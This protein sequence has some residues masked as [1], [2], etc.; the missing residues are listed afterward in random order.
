MKTLMTIT[1]CFLMLGTAFSQ[2]AGPGPD[3]HLESLPGLEYQKD[4]RSN[5]STLWTATLLNMITADVLSLYIPEAVEEWEEFA[6]GKEEQLMMGGAIMYQLPISMVYLSKVLPYKANRIANMTAAG[7]MIAAVIGGGSTE[8]HYLVCATTEV[9]MM[10]AIAWKAY[11]WE[12][13]DRTGNRSHN[14][15]LNLNPARDTY[16]M[17]YTLKF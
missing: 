4:M 14:F 17:T 13:P 6:D 1:I 7:L 5:L 16:G 2:T 10:S 11:K 3:L 15:D 8:P 12:S 9:I